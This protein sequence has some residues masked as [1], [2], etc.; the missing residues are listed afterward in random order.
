MCSAA[1]YTMIAPA[2]WPLMQD[3]SRCEPP[4]TRDHGGSGQV[5][6]CR[7]PVMLM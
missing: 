5:P 1:R 4:R 3:P 6:T 7:P 2:R